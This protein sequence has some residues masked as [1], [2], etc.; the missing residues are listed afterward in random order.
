M[1]K[2]LVADDDRQIVNSIKEMLF[3]YYDVCVST[4]GFET[5]KHCTEEQFDGLITDIDFGPGMSGL[6]VAT[7]IRQQDKSIRIMV[8]SAVDYSDSVRQQVVDIGANFCEKPLS[9]EFIHRMMED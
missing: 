8:F 7:L 6:E 1:R 2:I 5:L 4:S 9:I 3:P